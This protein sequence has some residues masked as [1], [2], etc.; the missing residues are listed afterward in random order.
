MGTNEGD[1]T[2]DDEKARVLRVAAEEVIYHVYDGVIL[3]C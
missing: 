1:E 2:A 3:G